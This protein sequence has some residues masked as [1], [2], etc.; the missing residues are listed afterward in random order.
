M[1][2]EVKCLHSNETNSFCLSLPEISLRIFRIRVYRYNSSS[3]SCSCSVCV[4][5]FACSVPVPLRV[6][7]WDFFTCE[8]FARR[9]WMRKGIGIWIWI[10]MEIVKHFLS[11]AR[12]VR[13]S[14]SLPCHCEESNLHKDLRQRERNYRGSEKEPKGLKAVRKGI[15]N[16]HFA[17][18]PFSEC[19]HRFHVSCLHPH[20]H[21]HRH[22]AGTSR[23]NVAHFRLFIGSQIAN[24]QTHSHGSPRCVVIGNLAFAKN[25]K[26]ARVKNFFRLKW[27][28]IFRVIFSS[29]AF[30]VDFRLCSIHARCRCC[31][32]CCAV[33]IFCD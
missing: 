33:H 4:R 26:I 16:E 29:F 18:L 31:C 24:S 13:A 23:A 19:S 17:A 7:A 9:I 2:W 12:H 25:G 32:C 10:W 15:F 21:H 30:C 22:S 14:Y 3:S 5:T 6:T 1:K 11:L 27:R 20:H 8:F 28:E